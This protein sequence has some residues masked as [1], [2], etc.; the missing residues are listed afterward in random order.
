[1][2]HGA[3]TFFLEVLMEGVLYFL[4][5]VKHLAIMGLSTIALLITETKLSTSQPAKLSPRNKEEGSQL[6]W[7]YGTLQLKLHI[8]LRMIMIIGLGIWKVMITEVHFLMNGRHVGF[9]Q[10]LLLS[11]YVDL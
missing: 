3:L 9:R 4:H 2:K 5:F 7:R 1:M 6:I 11:I 8:K 10:I